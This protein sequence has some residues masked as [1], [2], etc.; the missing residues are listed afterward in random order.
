ML[1]SPLGCPPSGFPAFG[2][3]CRRQ[4]AK[5]A[6]AH[7]RSRMGHTTPRRSLP[8]PAP[9]PCRGAARAADQW[10]RFEKWGIAFT[11]ARHLL[12]FPY[13]GQNRDYLQPALPP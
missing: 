11:L 8:D 5:P 9:P 4:A 2:Y 13:M 1:A 12:T 7:Q 10:L 6:Y 3:P